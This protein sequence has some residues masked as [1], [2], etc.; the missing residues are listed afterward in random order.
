[1]CPHGIDREDHALR[2]WVLGCA[3]RLFSH[4]SAPRIDPPSGTHV[5]ELSRLGESPC[6]DARRVRNVQCQKRV[7]T[8]REFSAHFTAAFPARCPKACPLEDPALRYPG[9]SS[10][11]RP[12]MIFFGSKSALSAS[13]LQQNVT[14]YPADI[15]IRT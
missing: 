4:G 13:L 2:V 12:L 11:K 8:R 3:H 5:R 14:I 6:L 9:R 15:L 1:M 7:D 10:C